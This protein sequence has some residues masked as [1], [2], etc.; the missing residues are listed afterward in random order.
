MSSKFPKD[1]L[2]QAQSVL[3]GWNQ[4]NPVLPFGPLTT[5]TF[6]SDL[7]MVSALDVEIAGLEAQLADKYNQRETVAL[8]LWDKVKRVRNSI[9]GIYGDDSSQYEMVGG[10]R[11]SERRFRTRKRVVTE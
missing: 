1:L 3:A 5:T 4:L 2:T 6:S 10:I 11:M 9:K 7:T 8:S